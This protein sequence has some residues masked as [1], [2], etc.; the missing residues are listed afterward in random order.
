MPRAS[1]PGE[2]TRRLTLEMNEQ[3]NARLEALREQTG[4]G[5]YAEV[6]RKALAVYEFAW[7]ERERKRKLVSIAEDDPNDQRELVLL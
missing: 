2:T 6:I 7:A 1:N 3:V 5:S 4:S